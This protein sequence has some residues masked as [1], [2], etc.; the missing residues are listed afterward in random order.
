MA[1]RQQRVV[2]HVNAT[3]SV[4]RDSGRG[5]GSRRDTGRRVHDT[6][7]DYKQSDGYRSKE[8]DGHASTR[9]HSKAGE[10][11]S[12][13]RG[14]HQGYAYRRDSSDRTAV[15]VS[16]VLDQA[17]ISGDSHKPYRGRDKYQER[18]HYQQKKFSSNDYS[19]MQSRDQRKKPYQGHQTKHDQ[20]SSTSK[21]EAK[22]EAKSHVNF[23]SHS[24][25]GNPDLHTG[26]DRGPYFDHLFYHGYYNPIMA[27][28]SHHSSYDQV[29]DQSSQ[30]RQDIG[31]GN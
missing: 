6:K 9:G 29:N 26:I 3:S 17:T 13:G 25:F 16:V 18:N 4:Q 23:E 24:P 5:R 31:R 11:H 8:S 22:S 28:M 1:S 12:R 20:F 21:Y 7:N 27:M 2:V 10:S 15:E 14:G 30:N 19:G